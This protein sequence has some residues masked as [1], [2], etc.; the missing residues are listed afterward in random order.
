MPS[1]RH[2]NR[3]MKMEE[4]KRDLVSAEQG[5]RVRTQISTR[6]TK[7][8]VLGVGKTFFLPQLRRESIASVEGE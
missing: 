1:M 8:L 7:V 2:V 5:K 6:S 4:W 3:K